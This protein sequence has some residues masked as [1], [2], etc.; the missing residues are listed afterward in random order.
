MWKGDNIQIAMKL[1]GQNGLWE[2]GLSR[3]RDNSGEAFCW[4]APAGFPGGE[5]RRGDPAGNFAGREGE[6]DRLP[7][8]DPLPGDRPDGSGGPVGASAST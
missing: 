4:L 1:P 6:A 8:G 2:L 7:R 3:L 5:N